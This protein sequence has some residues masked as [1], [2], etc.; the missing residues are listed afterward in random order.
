MEE[1]QMAV[2]VCSYVCVCV[3]VSINNELKLHLMTWHN[4]GTLGRRSEI[5]NAVCCS[6]DDVCNGT[7]NVCVISIQIK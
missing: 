5:A 6:F 4:S 1:A 7:R 2:C 3:W